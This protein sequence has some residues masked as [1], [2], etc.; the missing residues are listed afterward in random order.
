MSKNNR[1]IS[2]TKEELAEA[3]AICIF[4]FCVAIK[5]VDVTKED[6]TRLREA[7]ISSLDNEEDFLRD[8][9]KNYKDI[10]S[11]NE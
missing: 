8:L 10:M 2:T 5:R 6:I 11:H 7:T 9:S 3:I 1:F 4:G